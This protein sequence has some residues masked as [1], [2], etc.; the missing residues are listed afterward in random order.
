MQ[1][2]PSHIRLEVWKDFL[3]GLFFLATFYVTRFFVETLKEYWKG[4]GRG[5]GVWG[6]KKYGK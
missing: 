2:K 1:I 6:Y 5:E 3:R 4:K